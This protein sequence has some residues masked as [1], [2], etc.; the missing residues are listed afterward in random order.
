MEEITDLFQLLPA[1]VPTELIW[2]FGKV[3][4]R[5]INREDEINFRLIG[6]KFSLLSVGVVREP[7]SQLLFKF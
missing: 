3:P 6:T 2:N 4:P 1:E 7:T 5:S